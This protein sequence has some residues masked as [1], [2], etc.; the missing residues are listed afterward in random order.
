MRKTAALA[1]DVAVRFR[2]GNVFADCPL[3]FSGLAEIVSTVF[4]GGP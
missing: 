2:M 4:H 1:P 3:V